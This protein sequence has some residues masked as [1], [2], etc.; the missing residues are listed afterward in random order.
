M[1]MYMESHQ[2][3]WFVFCAKNRLTKENEEQPIKSN[4]DVLPD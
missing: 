1:K 3:V 2:E 4:I